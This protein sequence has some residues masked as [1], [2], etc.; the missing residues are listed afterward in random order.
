MKGAGRSFLTAALALV[1]GLAVWT[2]VAAAPTFPSL[3]GRVVDGANIL[4]LATEAALTTKLEAL[5]NQTSRQL[6]I[7]TVP[8]LQGYEIEDYGYQLGRAWGIGEKGRNTGVLLLVAPNE[9][10]VRVEVGYGLEGVLT[11]ALSSVVL[12]ERVLPRFRTGDFEGGVV[13]GADAL[14]EQLSLPDDQARARVAASSAAQAAPNRPAPTVF[15][16]L[17]GLWVVLGFIG[18]VTGRPGHRMDLWLLPL[19]LLM[20]GAGHGGRRRGGGGFRGGGGSFGGGGA[21]GGW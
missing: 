10:R 9:R 15:L 1:A 13:A 21:S 17:L 11:D 18:M 20:S 19:L 4:S 3:N 8:S 6:V 16:V 12:Q 2:A 5:E 14:I 7:V